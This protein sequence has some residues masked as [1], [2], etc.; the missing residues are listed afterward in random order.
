MKLKKLTSLILT[1]L[2]LALPLQQ[3]SAIS[4]LLA[5]NGVGGG[6]D[7]IP[8]LTGLGYSVTVS[9]AATWGATFDYS[10]FD[11]VAFEY[12]SANPANIAHLVSAVTAGDVGVVFFRG[13]GTE[14]TAQALGLITGG[15]MNWQSPT[16]LNVT[17]NTHYITEDL[18]LG[19]HNLGYTYMTSVSTAAA[20]TTTLASGSSG[21]AL[22]VS[23]T[24]RAVITPFYGHSAN[25]NS[26]TADGLEI[27]QRTIEWAAGA[28]STPSGVPD[29]GA[30]SAL[31][32]IG[33]G[34]LGFVKRRKPLAA[35]QS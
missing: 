23:N 30:T 26:E 2:G 6:V 22:I 19:T 28:N 20:G 17:N 8:R 33:L 21:G 13:Y 15:S 7:V 14:S 25:Y 11:V 3:A 12:N 4:I 34:G 32:L 1:V 31:L 16:T 29:A 5:D 18:T 35:R 10:P 27:T 24:L 9:N